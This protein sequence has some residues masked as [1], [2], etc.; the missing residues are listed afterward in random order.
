[1][2]GNVQP[3][4]QQFPIVDAQGRPT[5]YFIQW[6]QQR[7]NDI[8]GSAQLKGGNNFTGDQNIA[9]KITATEGFVPAYKIKTAGPFVTEIFS[10]RVCQ[11]KV[12]QIL[13]QNDQGGISL[14]CDTGSGNF[15]INNGANTGGG[16]I[17]YFSA[18][19]RML[20]DQWGIQ[21][22]FEFTATPYVNSNK[23]FHEGNLSFGTGLTYNAVTGVLTA[24]GGGASY[25]ASPTKPAAASFTLV[26][27]GT[28]TLADTALGVAALFPSGVTDTIHLAQWN[29]SV[30]SATFTVTVR[31]RPTLMVPNGNHYQSCLIIRNSTNDRQVVFGDWTGNTQTLVQ[32]WTTNAAFSGNVVAPVTCNTA[33]F[34]WRR[35]VCTAGTMSFEASPDGVT[36]TSIGTATLASFLTAAG[37]TADKVGIGTRGVGGDVCYSLVLA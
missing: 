15:V 14:S 29:T 8:G 26:N 32:N 6:A 25:E 3:L 10:S 13:I 16:F 27:G 22:G 31:L 11:I 33:A 5:L 23:I 36:W 28:G 20:M 2:T 19:N 9:G 17:G 7:Q 37:G 4:D 21:T 1:M 35:V 34:P 18:N 12:D 30:A 24:S